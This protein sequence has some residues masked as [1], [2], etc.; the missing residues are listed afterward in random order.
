MPLYSLVDEAY[1]VL[2]YHSIDTLLAKLGE[3]TY[4][5]SI[6]DEQPMTEQS[7]LAEMN[8]RGVVRLYPPGFEDWEYKIRRHE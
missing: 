2:I 5:L 6:D 7:F 1:D 4:F 8:E 3:T